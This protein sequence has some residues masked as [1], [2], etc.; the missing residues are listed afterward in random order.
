MG[1]TSK[2]DYT[3]IYIRTLHRRYDC[4]TKSRLLETRCQ[5]LRLPLLFL[6]LSKTQCRTTIVVRGSA[7]TRKFASGTCPIGVQSSRTSGGFLTKAQLWSRA[8]LPCIEREPIPKPPILSGPAV[9][10]HCLL[11]EHL[12]KIRHAIRLL[13]SAAMPHN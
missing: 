10:V 6:L 3:N 2:Y 11:N 8:L 9:K 13:M 7:M 5:R 1:K 4:S 12:V